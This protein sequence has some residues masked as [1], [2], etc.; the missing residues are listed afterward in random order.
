MIGG[1][2]PYCDRC[3]VTDPAAALHGRLEPGDRGK[4]PVLRVGGRRI[5]WSL[6]GEVLAGEGGIAL[7]LTIDPDRDEDPVIVV[8]QGEPDFGPHPPLRDPVDELEA[9][10]WEAAVALLDDCLRGNSRPCPVEELH[11]ACGQA[12]RGAAMGES[13]W[14]IVGQAAGWVAGPPD[15]DVDLW[16]GAAM[17]LVS[18]AVDGLDEDVAECLDAMELNDWLATVIELVRAGPGAAAD[19]Q[20]LVALSARC[21]DVDSAAVDAD[22]AATMAE[23][24]V[25]LD[26]VWR[27]LGAVDESGCLTVLG[28]WGLPLALARAWGGWLS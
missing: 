6:I 20:T 14:P 4:G 2:S 7:T 26:R 27:L 23:A 22:M 21:L 18:V 3:V 28:A 13:P 17:A 12:R 1:R 5:P 9:E 25:A 24:F 8:Q 16:T 15:D 11:A 10:S 19:P